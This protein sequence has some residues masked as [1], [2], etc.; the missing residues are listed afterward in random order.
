MGQVALDCRAPDVLYTD[1][2]L[3]AP[4]MYLA[5]WQDC[6]VACDDS[7]SCE[8]YSYKNNTDPPGGCWLFR[9]MKYGTNHSDVEALTGRKYCKIPE[10]PIV[11]VQL[12][13]QL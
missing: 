9:N 12:I 11:V 3:P 4:K 10:T 2:M 8:A 6:Q 5:K 1:P 7:E 13:M